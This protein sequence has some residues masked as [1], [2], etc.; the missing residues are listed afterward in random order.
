MEYAIACWTGQPSRWQIRQHPVLIYC[1]NLWK[2]IKI[3]LFVG[4]LNLIDLWTISR[5]ITGVSDLA[6]Q[7][8]RPQW[9]RACK[10]I[11]ASIARQEQCRKASC[12]IAKLSKK[13]PVSG[14]C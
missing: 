4:N 5:D 12:I 8:S 7:C 9:T 6:A 3:V 10:R 14:A 1:L 11:T 13:M 2:H